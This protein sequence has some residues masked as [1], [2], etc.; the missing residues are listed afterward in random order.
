[1]AFDYS[2]PTLGYNKYALYFSG[3]SR[4][5]CHSKNSKDDIIS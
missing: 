3:A 2:N 4:S 1:M 5:W